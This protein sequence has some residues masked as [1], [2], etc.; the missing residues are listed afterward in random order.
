MKNLPRFPVVLIALIAGA[1]HTRGA[2]WKPHTVRQLNGTEREVRLDAQLQIVTES[3]NRV[4]ARSEEH[5][6]NSSHIQKSRMPSSA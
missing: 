5:S 2:D 3:W 1:S 6:L 4:V